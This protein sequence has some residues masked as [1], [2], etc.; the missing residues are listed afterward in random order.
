MSD[1]YGIQKSPQLLGER[2]ETQREIDHQLRMSCV[3]KSSY[4]TSRS[5][6]LG[7]RLLNF[8][9]K[10]I[11]VDYQERLVLK[12]LQADNTKVKKILDILLSRKNNLKNFTNQHLSYLNDKAIGNISFI[13][14]QTSFKIFIDRLLTKKILRIFK[15]FVDNLTQYIKALPLLTPEST[16]IVIW[17]IIAILSKLYFLYLIPLELAWTNIPLL[18]SRYY[19]STIIMLIILSIDFIIGFN[20]AYY[21]AGSLITNR[22]QIFKHHITKSYGLEWISTIILIILFIACKTTDTIINVTQN[23]IYLVLLSVLSHQINVHYKASQYESALNLSKKVSSCLELLKFLLL[24]F[25]VIHL[26]SCLWFWVGNYSKEN[27]E[28][29]WLDTL[30]YLPIIDW[31][32]EYLQSFYY[33]C[34]TMFT[35][36]YG[37]ITPKSGLEKSICIVLILIS[38]I[39]LPY[40]INTVGSI[41]EKISD[42]GEETKNKLRTINSYMNKKKVPYN[43][44]IQ[45]RQYLNHYWTSLQGQ[46]TEEEK[47][48]IS[49]LSLNLREQLIIQANSRIFAKVTLLK[50]NFSHQLQQKLLKKVQQI[51]MQPEQIIELDN[52]IQCYFVDEGEINI[53]IESGM[54]VQKA[55]KD[56]VVGLDNLF[57]GF[58]NKNQN[59]KSIGFTKLLI[60]SRQDFLQELKEFPND[61]EKFCSIRD[62]LLFNF[63]SSYIK[64][65]CDSCYQ[66]GH[67]IID[68][69]MLHYVPQ[70][71]F[72]IKRIQYPQQQGRQEFS[73]RYYKLSRILLQELE[74]PD[75]SESK[76]Q[77]LKKYYLPQPA[78]I[79]SNNINNQSFLNNFQDD[80]KE[81]PEIKIDNLQASTTLAQKQPTKRDSLLSYIPDN[82][83]DQIKRSIN[84]NK[85]I[86][87][88]QSNKKQQVDIQLD[89]MGLQRQNSLASRRQSQGINLLNMYQLSLNNNAQKQNYLQELINTNY[90]INFDDELKLRYENLTQNKNM[91]ITD[92]EAIELL[93]LKQSNKQKYHK[94][95]LI[96]FETIKNFHDYF[97][98]HNVS[99]SIS[100]ANKPQNVQ[101]QTQIKKFMG[102]LLYPSEFIRKFKI[103]QSDNL[104][105]G[106]ITEEENM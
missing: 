43:L 46:D 97:P 99:I 45:I 18:Y 51:Q 93:Y 70:K 50:Q 47:V 26:F 78:N 29:T 68:C 89:G 42:Y 80:I 8:V 41:I 27:D 2:L 28:F 7:Q 4:L 15:P 60:L 34:V 73:R 21:N 39:Q 72:L 66:Y 32:D 98:Q 64:K 24:L 81:K 91:K 106:M 19:T 55:K 88:N 84:N 57:L 90:E 58:H 11:S 48:I 37:D 104:K 13:Q 85:K 23:P 95:G 3:R 6:S 10:Q 77:F 82:N 54:V 94:K 5:K 76:Q 92:K 16:K 74:N 87:V 31:T 9:G 65:Q 62:D 20:T 36:G 101:I 100:R 17:D 30:E 61:Y 1:Q 56:D 12:T 33:V 59:I 38:S 79:N 35:V 52:N 14:K 22:I 105:I 44:Q 86:G 67:E 75:F 63:K 103:F 71:D 96:E 25:Y 69:S 40:S 102:Y 83:I 49:Q 53:I